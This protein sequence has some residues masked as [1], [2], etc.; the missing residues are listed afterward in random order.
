MKNKHDASFWNK[1]YAGDSYL[2]GMEPNAFLVEHCGLLAG[3]VLS[4]SEGEGRNS[5]F[6]AER[7]LD[8]LGVDIS[9]VALEKAKRLAELRGVNIRTELADLATYTPKENF[10][11][12]V[13]SISAHLPGGIRRRLYPLIERALKPGGTILLEAYSENQ[14]SRDT[15]GPGDADMLMSVEKIRKEFPNLTPILLRETERKV[16][17]GNGHTGMAC[18][19]QF[20]A[21]K[22]D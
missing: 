9:M 21:R 10:Y 7:G 20:I 15:G 4:I 1:R 11:G 8:I 14:L 16:S 12:S 22:A 18:V 2:Y 3:P 5:V 6:L 19:V 17:E 13:I